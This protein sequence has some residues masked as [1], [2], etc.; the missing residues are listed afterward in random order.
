MMRC[1]RCGT[2][3]EDGDQ[4]CGRCGSVLT[5]ASA[6]S[7]YPPG[8]ANTAQQPGSADWQA[9][10]VAVPRPLSPA[11]P[12]ASSGWA[13]GTWTQPPGSGYG[14]PTAPQNPSAAASMQPA[15]RRRRWPLNLLLF[16]LIVA[17]LV[18]GAWVLLLRPAVHQSVDAEIRQGLQSAV[19]QIPLGAAQ[20]ASANIPFPIPEDQINT[21]IGEHTA[22]LAP[23]TDMNVTLQPGVMVITFQAY[24]F[25]STVRLG[26]QAEGGKLA[27]TNV[28]VSGLLWWVES[29]DELTPRLN[30]A[31]SQASSNLGRQIS[32]V[33][34]DEGLIQLT[35]V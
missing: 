27:A 9:P 26:L 19:G 31:L 11:Q 24:G 4:F 10:T 35:F 28:E 8:G 18:A 3:N 12:G 34:I 30:D 21:Y 22:A 33:S 7:F 29:A 23:I 2:V 20:R 15:R 17:L 6:A 25:G 14:P 1:Q 5:G 13:A 32:S 16:V